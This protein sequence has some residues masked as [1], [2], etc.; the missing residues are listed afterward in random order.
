MIDDV[1]ILLCRI[2]DYAPCLSSPASTSH[3]LELRRT[4]AHSIASAGQS[5]RISGVYKLVRS[6][7]L[8]RKMRKDIAVVGLVW[9]LEKGVVLTR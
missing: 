9:L 6:E 8:A 1:W 5:R 3:G 2:T 7:D 4:S